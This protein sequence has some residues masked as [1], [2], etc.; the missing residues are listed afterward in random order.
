MKWHHKKEE[1]L[2]KKETR[3]LLDHLVSFRRCL[4]KLRSHDDLG[5]YFEGRSAC[6]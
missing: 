5:Y 2:Y 1:R 3:L 6:P 4:D